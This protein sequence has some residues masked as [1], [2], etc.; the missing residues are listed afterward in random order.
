[1]LLYYNRRNV[2][3]QAMIMLL[4]ILQYFDTGSVISY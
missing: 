2:F 4:F 3:I 1:M